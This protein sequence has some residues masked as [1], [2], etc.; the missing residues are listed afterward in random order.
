LEFRDG[1]L[2]IHRISRDLQLIGL[3]S[4]K[5]NSRHP[6]HTP[7]EE[8]SFISLFAPLLTEDFR[9]ELLQSP[10]DSVKNH[11]I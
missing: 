8:A 9:R 3:S 5:Q 7:P 11:E 6:P 4:A 2:V 1:T 10:T